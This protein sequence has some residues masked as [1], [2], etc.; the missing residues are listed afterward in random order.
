M[1]DRLGPVIVGIGINIRVDLADAD[2][3]DRATNVETEAGRVV[4]RHV[5]LADLLRRV[6]YWAARAQEPAL[7]EAWRGWLGTLGKRV[8]IY[9]KAEGDG[10]EYPAVAEAVR[11]ARFRG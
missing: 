3:T 1:G 2:L 9:P 5:I 6:D 11:C 4:D 10:D 7:I 8:T